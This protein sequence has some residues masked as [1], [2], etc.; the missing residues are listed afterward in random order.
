MANIAGLSIIPI[1]QHVG[2]QV[3]GDFAALFRRGFEV[4]DDFLCEHIRIR[5]ICAQSFQRLEQF[6]RLERLKPSAS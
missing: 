4:C 5:G 1:F 3:D 6:E 2:I